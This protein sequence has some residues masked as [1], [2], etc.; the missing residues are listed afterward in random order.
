M[1]ATSPHRTT[2]SGLHAGDP[3]HL[4]FLLLRSALTVAPIVAGVDKFTRLLTD[5]DK[6]LAP[7]INHLVP[8]TAHQAMMAVGVVEVAAGVL[9]AV[10][11]RIG[12]L[13]V[14][15]WLAGIIVDLVSMGAYLDVALRDLGLLLAA[16]AL[17]L[18]AADQRV[19]AGR[20]ALRAGSRA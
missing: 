15:L 6:Y 4:A 3:A 17:S 20:G 19:R 7:W 1:T 8:G 10:R 9:V 16:V 13:V 5:W 2:T 11:P 12:G 18:L 14:A